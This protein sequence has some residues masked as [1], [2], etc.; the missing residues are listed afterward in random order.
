MV[1][2]KNKINDAGQ[3]FDPKDFYQLVRSRWKVI[4]STVVLG[5]GFVMLSVFMQTPQYS[6]TAELILDPRS[7]NVVEGEAVFSNLSVDAISI[8]SEV[9]IMKSSH[10]AERVI[11][12]LN[13]YQDPEFNPTL[14]NGSFSLF[15]FLNLFQMSVRA[16]DLDNKKESINNQELQ[17]IIRKFSKNVKVKRVGRTYII[18]VSFSSESPNKAAQIANSVANAYIVSQLEARFEATRT[19]NNWLN[20]RLATLQKKLQVSEKAIEL[21]IAKNNLIGTK[22]KTPFEAE[23]E[24]LNEKLI[25]ARI[26]LNEKYTQYQQVR[27]VL[28]KKGRLSTIDVLAGSEEIKKLRQARAKLAKEETELITRFTKRHPMVVSKRSERQSLERQIEV[29]A[30]K[31]VDNIKTKYQSIKNK[32]VLIQKNIE[33]LKSKTQGERTASIRL[34]ELQRDAQ[35][36]RAV[37]ESFLNRFKQTSQQETLKTA[38][39]R[40]ITQAVPN[41]VPSFPNKTR[42]LAL[43]LI[44]FTT[45]GLGL[46]FLLEYFDN[47]IKKPEQIEEFLQ[48]SHLVSIPKLSSSDTFYEGQDIPIERFSVMRPLTPFAEAMRTL[49]VG[50]E[51]SN[52]DRPPKVVLMTSVFPNEGKTTICTNFAQHAAQVGTRTLLIDADLRNPSLTERLVKG[53][54]KG[55]IELLSRQISVEEAIIRDHTGVDILPSKSVPYNS[56]EIL[57]SENMKALLQQLRSMYGLIVFDASPV[58]PVIDAKVLMQ[59]VDSLVLVVEWDKTPKDAILNVLNTLDPER[60]KLTGIVLNKVDLKK[61]QGSAYSGYGGYYGH[62]DYQFNNS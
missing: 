41:S 33:E 36:N 16:E 30:L 31:V 56:A 54:D 58:M 7:K 11:N 13:L 4:F 10:I 25:L 14:S 47:S 62:S 6:S 19:A 50:L 57:R 46:A 49:K 22:G 20:E 23:L 40:I 37:Y 43:A 55:L 27:N 42:A 15:G 53:Y 60:E 48:A 38:D 29:E 35:A 26:E 34:R 3:T 32:V 1:V 8:A 59:I 2:D 12:E 18:A 39:T 51:L 21:Y 28:R 44:G 5:V 17:D 24:K 45:L 52:I 61:V 9:L